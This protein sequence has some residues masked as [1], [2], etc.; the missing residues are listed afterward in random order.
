MILKIESVKLI[1][2]INLDNCKFV[3]VKKDGSSVNVDGKNFSLRRSEDKDTYD[4][5][6]DRMIKDLD[7]WKLRS[8]GSASACGS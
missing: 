2:Y 4:E 7:Q 5:S 8:T 6:R 3:E 1:S